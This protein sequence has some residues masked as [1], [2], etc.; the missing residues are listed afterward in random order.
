MVFKN[1]S[2]RTTLLTIT[3]F[4][5][6]E[7]EIKRDQNRSPDSSGNR[8]CRQHI[9]FI[10]VLFTLNNTTFRIQKKTILF[11][12]GLLLAGF[13]SAQQS[14][15]GINIGLKTGLSKMNTEITSDYTQHLTEFNQQPGIAVDLEFSKFLAHH[16][17]VG[18]SINFNILSGYSDSASFTAIYSDHYKL[19]TIEQGKAVEYR[20]RL[21]GQRFFVGYYFR[22][23]SKIHRLSSPEPFIQI[24]LGYIDY[25]VE[26]KY[27]ED[28]MLIFSK[29]T[30]NS[31]GKTLSTAIYFLNAGV[32]YYL[33]PGFF[34]NFTYTINYVPYDFLDGV[35]N[36][37]ADGS[38]ADMKGLFSEIK[39]GF[40]FQ[41]GGKR[42][43][44]RIKRF[45]SGSFLPFSK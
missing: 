34:L 13:A 9:K 43:H 30:D 12:L 33:S 42:R 10:F 11:A 26:L 24:G 39:I 44:A 28:G 6:C 5:L 16:F 17:E 38:R 41:T 19:S 7:G 14:L 32:K 2:P 4:F 23:F 18:T 27:Q 21:I 45:R 37:N 25:A 22:D 1:S 20:N 31:D 8:Y 35:Y 29:G 3:T 40:F 15:T 36:Y